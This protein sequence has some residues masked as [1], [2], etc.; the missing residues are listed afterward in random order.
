MIWDYAL[1]IMPCMIMKK[2]VNALYASQR[3]GNL[4]S[5]LICRS[6]EENQET[7]ENSKRQ[8]FGLN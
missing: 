5:Y 2:N 4:G 1:S 6:R 3:G 8:E 7:D